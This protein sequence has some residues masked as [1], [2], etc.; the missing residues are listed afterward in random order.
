MTKIVVTDQAGANQEVDITCEVYREAADAGLTV[1]QYLDR[2]IPTDAARSGTAFEQAMAQA[3]L[4]QS[5]DPVAGIRPPTMHE[6]MH[7]GATLNS[8]A[9][10]AGVITRDAQPA[11]RIL[12]PAVVMEAIESQLRYDAGDYLGLFNRMVAVND[13]VAG[14]RIE[15][16]VINFGPV[17]TS[18]ADVKRSQPVAQNSYPA[19]M[20]S[21]TTA[22]VAKK[23][24]TFAIGL[25]MTDEALQATSLPLVTMAVTRQAEL[26]SIARTDEFLQGFIWGDKDVDMDAL[27]AV[28]PAFGGSLVVKAKALDDSIATGAAGTV[29]T[30][31]AWVKWL[32]RNYRRRHIDFVICT[33]GTALAIEARS[34]RPTYPTQDQG[35]KLIDPKPAILNPQWDDVKMFIVEDNV[36]PDGVVVGL[37]SRY[38]IRR[39]RNSQA[40]Y[41]AVEQFVLKKT[42]A[43]RFD[44]GEIAYRLF[45]DSWDV[46]V[47]GDQA[48]PADPRS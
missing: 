15:Q 3:G 45:D 17:G 8:G 4:F 6:I 31:K 23:I 12:F 14:A 18:P 9:L 34:G 13:T 47:L 21:I 5:A 41:T 27:T 37:D 24:P 42:Q 35:A 32:R 19:S 39:I 29:L 36:L 40:D 26:E 25:E 7:G 33:V 38:A 11:S 10:S 28:S 2:R 48:M 44:F 22:D 1:R 46:L 16:P 20:V 43:M 30:Q